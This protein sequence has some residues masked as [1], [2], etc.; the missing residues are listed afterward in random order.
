MTEPCKFFVPTSDGLTSPGI[1]TAKN[2]PCSLPCLDKMNPSLNMSGVLGIAITVN[3][4]NCTTGI[5]KGCN[6]YWRIGMLTEKLVMYLVG[7]YTC[8]DGKGAGIILSFCTR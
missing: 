2:N 8:S 7:E 1:L 6:A 4:S 3:H 5:N